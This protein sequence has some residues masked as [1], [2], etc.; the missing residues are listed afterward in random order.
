MTTLFLYSV[1][2]QRAFAVTWEQPAPADLLFD[3]PHID[4]S[5]P[6]NTTSTTVPNSPIYTDERLLSNRTEINAHNWNPEQLDEF[7]ATFDDRFGENRN[8]SWLQVDFNRG[9]VMRSFSYPRI[10]PHLD[11]LGLQVTTAY[12]CLIQYLFRPKPAVLAFVA[13]YASFFALPEVF[14]IGIQIR[15]G[16]LSMVSSVPVTFGHDLPDL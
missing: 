1:V 11:R 6:F 3:S 2:T 5:R 13:E 15:T 14:V 12:S 16:D 9:I 4:W 7:M 8:S 10:R